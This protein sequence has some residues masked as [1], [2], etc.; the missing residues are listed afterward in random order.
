MVGSKSAVLFTGTLFGVLCLLASSAAAESN[1]RGLITSSTC[2]FTCGDLGLKPESCRE[3]EA[4]DSCFV[5]DLSQAPGHRS[6]MR[7][8]GAAGPEAA[9]HEASGARGRMRR[10]TEGTWITL[11]NGEARGDVARNPSKPVDPSARGLVT[12]APCPYSCESA[13]L[14]SESCREWRDGERCHVED[15]LQA[16]GHR[17]AILPGR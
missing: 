16:P 13:G 5:E 11:T 14:P 10:D 9:V 7:V 3:W 17:S 2:P 12:T 4:G 8:P 15:L 1:R 6:L